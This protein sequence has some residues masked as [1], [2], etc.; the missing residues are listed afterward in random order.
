M[1][2]IVARA[3][4]VVDPDAWPDRV[5]AV[6][7]LL[8]DG[9][10]FPRGVTFLVGEN[11]AGKSTLV[12]AI[13]GV[14]GAHVEGGTT[15]HHAGPERGTRSDRSTLPERLRVVRGA[16]GLKDAFFLRAET[17]HRFYDYLEESDRDS[18]IRVDHGYHRRS[19][20]EGF[21]DLLESRYVRDAGV[22]LLDEPESALSFDNCLVLAGALAAMARGGKQVLC[23]THSP[24]V[25]AVPGARI[26]QVDENGLTPVGWE[27]LRIVRNWR[28][29]LDA[30]E[31]FLRRVL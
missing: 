13:A 14:L 18:R 15:H 27:D 19:H 30:P 2:R 24:I 16:G 8:T 9:F 1:R 26:L 5:P 31:R 21:L 6:R 10:A 22:V 20:G 29:F 11:G 25:T 3:E 7:Q 12:E 23:A 17:M 28:F 4:T